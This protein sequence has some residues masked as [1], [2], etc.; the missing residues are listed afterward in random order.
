MNNDEKGYV[1]PTPV[2]TNQQVNAGDTML[3]RERNNIIVATNQVNNSINEDQI[4]ETNNKIKYKKIPLLVKFVSVVLSLLLIFFIS[5]YVIK[6]SKK[7]IEA[8]EETTTTTTTISA[9]TKSQDYWN[10]DIVRKYEGNNKIYLFLPQSIGPYVYEIAYDNTGVT[11]TAL[12]TYIEDTINLTMDDSYLF[13]VSPN[14]LTIDNEE[15]RIQSGEL[16]YYVGDNNEILI[17]NATP[18]VLQ[19]IYVTNGSTLEGAYMEY[20]D[21]ITLTSAQGNEYVFTKIAN[22]I[23]Y[24]GVN[25]SLNI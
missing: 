2:D 23:T 5:F 13:Q 25:L 7:F 1:T 8:G 21:R 24:N 15:Y 22:G 4:K 19:G 20:D 18:N 11:S 16:K 3:G 10:K 9:L 12:G 14:G 6:Y 17:I